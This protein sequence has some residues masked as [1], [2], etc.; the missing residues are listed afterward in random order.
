MTDFRNIIAEEVG[1]EP[2]EVSKFSEGSQHET[3]RVKYDGEKVVFQFAVSRG[4]KRRLLY[5][6]AFW[7]EILDGLELPVPSVLSDGVRRRG[8]VW[9]FVTD[10][11]DG[12]NAEHNVTERRVRNAGR[13]LAM[14]HES[15]EVDGMKFCEVDGSEV[16]LVE[17]DYSGWIREMY[18]ESIERF[19][20]NGM[21]D[22]AD[23]LEAV[24]GTFDRSVPTNFESV[25]CHND[26]SPDNVLFRGDEVTGI[27]DFDIAYVGDR[28]RDVVTGANG[29]WMHEP[30]AD[31][32]PRDVFYG[33]YEE[34]C[35]FGD[36]FWSAERFYRFETQVVTVSYLV[37]MG[38]LTEEQA[39]FY[40]MRIRDAL[41]RFFDSS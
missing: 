15:Y 28:Y 30:T 38:I 25:V 27:I 14:L 7:Y 2:E 37:D 16:S 22:L 26:Y 31:W 6:N 8:D 10:F 32:S 17:E 5:R 23:D 36:G 40:A 12:E 1:G 24:E 19:R 13:N 29:F 3:F 35:E 11:L 39:E 41:E 9:Y 4:R 18:R 34:V 20:D 21:N 33:G